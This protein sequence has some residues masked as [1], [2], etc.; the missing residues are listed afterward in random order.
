MILHQDCISAIREKSCMNLIAIVR[1][2]LV[3]IHVRK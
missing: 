2:Q 3:E 1:V